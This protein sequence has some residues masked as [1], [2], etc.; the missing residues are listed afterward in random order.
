MLTM[1]IAENLKT[2]SKHNE[3]IVSLIGENSIKRVIQ[4]RNFLGHGYDSLKPNIT[5]SAIKKELPLI[6]NKIKT[7]FKDAYQIVKSDF[8]NQIQTKK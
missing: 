2:I 3:Q 4:Q 7:H 6:K 8:L 5:L 1:A